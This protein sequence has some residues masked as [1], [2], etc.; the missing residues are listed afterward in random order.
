M[1]LAISEAM[2]GHVEMRDKID[3]VERVASEISQAVE[4]QRSAT[5]AI[6][7]HVRDVTDQGREL[8]N[9]ARAIRTDADAILAQSHQLSAMAN[10][11]AASAATMVGQVDGFLDELRAA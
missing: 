9:G 3:A 8:D 5:H 11:V 1:V 4:Y 2:T 6:A 10:G 7:H